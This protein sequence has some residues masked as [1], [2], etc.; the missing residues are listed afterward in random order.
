M[1]SYDINHLYFHWDIIEYDNYV[2]EVENTSD[3]KGIIKMKE[4]GLNDM[5][6]FRLNDGTQHCKIW[7]TNDGINITPIWYKRLLVEYFMFY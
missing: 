6:L 5:K 4:Y 1:P 2:C 7:F 3:N